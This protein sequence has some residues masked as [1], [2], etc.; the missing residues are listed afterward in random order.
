[1]SI[2]RKVNS[3]GNKPISPS[4]LFRDLRRDSNI[5]FLWDHQGKMLEEYHAS[6][7]NT[8]NVALELPTGTGKTLVG[9]LIGEY[10]RRAL[11][12]RVVYLCPTRQLC[13][14][15]LRQ[16]RHYGIECSLLIGQQQ[17][18]DSAHFSRYQR[19]DSIAITTYSGIFNSNPRIDDPEVII[20]M[21][22]ENKRQCNA[23]R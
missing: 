12:K 18:Y 21:V 6:Y 19:A 5:K 4:L 22:K 17:N 8:P 9:L 7:I 3:S 15:V 11:N 20:V 16:A 23:P 1:M 14:Q 2:F 13:H 10:Q